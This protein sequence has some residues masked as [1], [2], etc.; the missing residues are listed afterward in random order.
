M[1][2]G[3]KE[4]QAD[5][6]QKNMCIGCG[7]CV[8]ICPYFKTY[9]GKTAAMFQ[10]SRDSGRC[11][12]FCPKTGVD[13]DRL[14]E[15]LYNKKYNGDPL[16]S[17]KAVY[18]SEKGDK[19]SKG[20]FQNGGTVSAL[21]EFALKNKVID[22][23]ILTKRNG[24]VSIP[25][26]VTDHEKV[27]T[28]ASSKYGASPVVGMFN[29]G[30]ESGYKKIG[31]VGTPCSIIAM[32]N[33][34]SN[35]TDIPDFTDKSGMV[36]GLFCTWALDTVKLEDTLKD[37]IDLSLLQ[38]VDI[39]PPP[40]DVMT[41]TTSHKEITLP[42]NEIR[43]GIPLGC[44]YCHDMTGEFADISVGALELKGESKKNII[45]VRTERGEKL[46]ND[47]MSS[48]YIKTEPLP[49]EALEGL[50]TASMNK[51]RRAFARLADEKMINDLGERPAIVINDQSLKNIMND[52][53]GK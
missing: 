31:V 37:K 25:E 15:K 53:G 35:P 9:K 7:A 43:T 41:F 4:L 22:S 45:I 8:S 6:Q 44:S 40:A 11:Y 33:I 47:A 23:A 51:K 46:F 30:A 13:L 14:S 10:C 48:G 34:R 20:N 39:P 49:A 5:V 26:I 52:K 42:L 24:A 3:P 21:M 50:S 32:A 19:A 36:I 12:A 29:K 38:K 16:G 27:N 18:T 17:Y 1:T 28:Y 2:F